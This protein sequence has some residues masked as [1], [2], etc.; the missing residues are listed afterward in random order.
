MDVRITAP[1]VVDDATY[2]LTVRIENKG[3]IAV[4]VQ[5]KWAV[6][7]AGGRIENSNLE[8]GVVRLFTQEFKISQN[9]V[10]QVVLANVGTY[11]L[12]VRYCKGAD[13]E[14]T[15]ITNEPIFILCRQEQ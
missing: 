14:V 1:E 3:K 13:F 4:P 10:I 5:G 12:P 6:G 9:E 8:P 7:N 11:T 15:G 2:S